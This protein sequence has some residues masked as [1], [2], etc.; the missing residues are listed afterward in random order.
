MRLCGD[1]ASARRQAFSP[2]PRWS[3]DNGHF[4]PDGK[5]IVFTSQKRGEIESSRRRP[6]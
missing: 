1:A 3:D 2:Y 4:S 5:W 6:Q